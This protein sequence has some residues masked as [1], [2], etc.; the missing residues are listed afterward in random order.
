MTELNNQPV[1]VANGDFPTHPT[2]LQYLK[3][4]STIICCDGATDLCSQNGFKPDAIIGDLDSI[5]SQ[6]K[7]KFE[8]ICTFLPDQNENDLRKSI[9][10]AEDNDIK[11]LIIVGVSGK[12]E[13]H[14]IGNI[15][16]ILQFK[17]NLIIKIVTDYGEFLVLNKNKNIIDSFVG[18]QISIFTTD[19]SIK[20]TS[21]GLKYVLENTSLPFLYS[22]TLNESLSDNITLTLSHGKALI[23]KTHGE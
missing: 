13:D 5:S 1:L 3:H 4:A 19:D 16:S 6:S 2:P 15:F 21:E 9:K 22:G 12:R 17:T 10:W 20:F 11:Q 18:Q 8:S 23:F 7:N 14:S